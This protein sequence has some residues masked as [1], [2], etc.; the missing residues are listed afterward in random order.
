MKLRHSIAWVVAGSFLFTTLAWATWWC[1]YKD[2]DNGSCGSWSIIHPPGWCYS[3]E[4]IHSHVCGNVPYGDGPY[5]YCQTTN[6]ACTV[7]LTVWGPPNCT[8][9]K[10]PVQM[11]CTPSTAPQISGVFICPQ[12]G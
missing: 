5:L 7:T 9:P 6:T 12:D 4:C 11:R 3:G 8:V 1:P 10:P 2:Q